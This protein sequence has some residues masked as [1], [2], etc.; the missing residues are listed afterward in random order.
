MNNPSRFGWSWTGRVA[1]QV[2]VQLSRSWSAR[3][4]AACGF[5]AHRTRGVRGCGADG[6]PAA[7]IAVRLPGGMAHGHGN[8]STSVAWIGMPSPV[9]V[10]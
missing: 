10:S 7:A 4:N 9:T 8:G 1:V 2:Q 6:S 5:I 3:V